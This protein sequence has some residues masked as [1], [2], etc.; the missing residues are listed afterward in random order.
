MNYVSCRNWA[1]R[2]TS[3]TR[4]DSS[5]LVN[6]LVDLGYKLQHA[7][8][9]AMFIL[10]IVAK[11]VKQKCDHYLRACHISSISIRIITILCLLYDTLQPRVGTFTPV[12]DRASS[13]L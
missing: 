9:I 1:V 11:L 6:Q 3:G 5:S 2:N 10:S 8:Q 4:L 13:S 7:K 12:D